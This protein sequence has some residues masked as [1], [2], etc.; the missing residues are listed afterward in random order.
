MKGSRR[1]APDRELQERMTPVPAFFDERQLLHQPVR[2]MHNGGWTPYAETPERARAI[3]QRLSNLKP[4]KD[5]GLDPILGVHDAQYLEFLRD[6]HALWREA[7]RE[8]DAI[9]YAWPIVRRGDLR[10]ER[11][12]A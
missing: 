1:P 10:L 5:F 9:G 11:I 12:D 6:A 2:E 7:G 8:S 4:A 3:R